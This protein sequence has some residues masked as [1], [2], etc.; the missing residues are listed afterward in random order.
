MATGN[1][2]K[3]KISL[4][5]QTDLGEVITMQTELWFALACALLAIGYGIVSVK[6]ILAQPDG[7]ERMREIALAIQEGASAYLNRQ[8]TTIGIV[9]VVLCIVLWIALGASTAIGFAIG[10]VMSGAAGYIGMHISVRSN[11]RTAQAA[12]IVRALGHGGGTMSEQIAFDD[13]L[14]VDAPINRGNSGGPL[15]DMQ[16]QVI[17]INTWTD[18]EAGFG[19][20]GSLAHVA[21]GGDGLDQQ[22]GGPDDRGVFCQ[23]SYAVSPPT[24]SQSDTPK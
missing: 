17:G 2:S 24:T 6:W 11:V 10:A 4:H 1:P 22:S 15:F 13:F 18:R 5:P 21:D 7:N 20:G 23:K 3:N 14:Q 16:G 19:G 12:F 9:G 8:Y